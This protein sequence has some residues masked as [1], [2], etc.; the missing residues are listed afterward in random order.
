MAGDP[1]IHVEDFSV[2]YREKPVLWDLDADFLEGTRTA[3]VG[4]NGAGKSTLLK[5]ML[6]LL[7]PLSGRA[8]FWGEPYP[9]CRKRVAYVPQRESV[10]WD[11]PTHVLDVVTM[12][13][14]VHLRWCQRP[15]KADRE[16]AWEA[17]RIMEMEELANRQISQLSG[18]QQQRV[19]LARAICQ[20]ADLYLL[21]EPLAGVDQRTEA[22]VMEKLAALQQQGKTIV[23]VHHD[24][25]TIGKY[26][27]HALLLNRTVIASGTVAEVMTPEH[28]ARAYGMEER[29]V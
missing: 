25:E 22:L 14:Y 26:F 12:G 8:T 18:G 27:D 7:K 28:L 23:A 24:L 9:A 4:P 3:I 11:F 16:K 20:D 13:R 29:N 5:G 10:R 19:F 1:L 2:A 6:G 17:L 21:D 15:G